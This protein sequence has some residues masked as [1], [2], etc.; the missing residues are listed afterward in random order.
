M[1]NRIDRLE[2]LV[3]SLMTTEQGASTASAQASIESSRQPTSTSHSRSADVS[4]AQD[5]SEMFDQE[6]ED[7]DDVNDVS[8]GIGFMKVDGTKSLY[9]SDAHWHAILANVSRSWCL[10]RPIHLLI[11]LLDR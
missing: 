11:M 10:P 8:Q 7:S 4:M 3:L 6:G 5:E 2:S 1:Q 9:A